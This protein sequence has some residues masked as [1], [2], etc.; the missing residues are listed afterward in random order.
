MNCALVGIERILTAS[1][2]LN[3]IVQIMGAQ[4]ASNLAAR[5][6]FLSD[7]ELPAVQV[8]NPSGLAALVFVCEHAA[9]FIPASLG[10]LGLDDQALS[11]HI[12]WDSGA[13]EVAIGLC[14]S[15]DAPLVASRISRLV[16]DCN[17]A[18]D[19]PDAMP[20]QS[21]NYKVPGNA[22]L[23]QAQRRDRIE[24]VYQPFQKTLAQVIAAKMRAGLKPAIVTIHSFTP[25]YGGVARQVELGILHHQDSA[26]A[27]AMLAAAPKRSTL[28]VQRNQPYGPQDQVMHTLHLHGIANGL[29]NVMIEMR[30]D[31]LETDEGKNTMTAVLQNMIEQ[32]LRASAPSAAGDP[33]TCQE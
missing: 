18:S 16:Y 19:S 14:R 24:Q 6:P 33:Q 3:N 1:S 26:L 4:A 32:G 12:A 30:N 7:G 8:I 21:E 17:R 23:T 10:N 9:R 22:H 5:R 25:V 28:N 27:D 11:S 2:P 13:F 29:P 20:A 15:M 31:L